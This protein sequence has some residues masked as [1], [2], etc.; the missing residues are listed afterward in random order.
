MSDVTVEWE[1]ALGERIIRIILSF[2]L[3]ECEG[4]HGSQEKDTYL[5]CVLNWPER[6]VNTK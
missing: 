4:G 6:R 3:E 5:S 1:N 2:F